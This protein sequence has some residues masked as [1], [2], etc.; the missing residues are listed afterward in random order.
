MHAILLCTLVVTA[1]FG[2]IVNIHTSLLFH[3]DNGK[4]TMVRSAVM[5]QCGKKVNIHKIL[6]FNLYNGNGKMVG[7]ASIYLRRSFDERP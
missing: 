3:V 5:A 1:Q 6:L 7:S 2:K 4:G